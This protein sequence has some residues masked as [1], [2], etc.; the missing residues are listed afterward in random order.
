MEAWNKSIDE[1]LRETHQKLASKSRESFRHKPE[2]LYWNLKRNHFYWDDL[3]KEWE[4]ILRTNPEDFTAISIIL[5]KVDVL[6]SE[7]MM[8]SEVEQTKKDQNSLFV[9]DAGQTGR[10]LIKIQKEIRDANTDTAEDLTSLSEKSKKLGD[11][12]QILLLQHHLIGSANQVIYFMRQENGNFSKWKGAECARQWGRVE[13]IWKPILDSMIRMQISKEAI[14]I[15]RRLPNQD[16]RKKVVKE[17]QSRIK[18]T[19]HEPQSTVMDADLVFRDLQKIISLL[20]DEVLEAR[21]FVNQVAP[22]LPELAREL[23]KETE[24]QKNQIEEAQQN[25]ESSLSEKKEEL[26]NLNDQQQDI[27]NS[28]ENFAQALRQEANIQN[29]LD[30]EGREI[31]RDSD[32]AASLVE[33]SER[34]I[35]ENLTEA[36]QAQNEE[37]LV[38]ASDKTIQEQEDLIEELNLI[39]EHFENLNNQESVAETR[40][41]LRELEEELENAEQIEEQYAQAERLADLAKLAPEDL[42]EELEEELKSNKAMQ[43]ELSDLAQDTVED[44]NDQLEDALT[45]EEE[46][47]DELSKRRIRNYKS[48]SRK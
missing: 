32:D 10:A 18:S 13:T 30:E 22:T 38:S 27:G 19:R 16:Y 25:E 9:K 12:F 39:A 11:S 8:H 37:D 3:K 5:G 26:A 43:Q 34:E 48:K 44:A 20:K 15:M 1:I 47:I 4:Q 31:A 6:I 29:L 41:E 36:S 14:D 24:E 33:E 23:A 40:Q 7:T 2:E 28:V 45:K 35:E 42:L 21:T 46:L 17:M